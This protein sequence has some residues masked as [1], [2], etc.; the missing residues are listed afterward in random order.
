[1]ASWQDLRA[2]RQTGQRPT[3]PVI[4]STGH[5]RLDRNLRESGCLVITHKPGEMFHVELL[6]G[7]RVM[8]F[9]GRCERANRVAKSM[10]ARGVEPA[11]MQVWCECSA[12]LTTAPVSCEIARE[13]A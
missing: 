10:M 7:L 5:Y 3:L 8:L 12:E 13:W 1:M 4:V 2:L 11:Q 9:V 6:Q